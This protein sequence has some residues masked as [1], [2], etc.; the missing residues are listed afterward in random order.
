MKFNTSTKGSTRTVNYEGE[1]AYSMDAEL[2]L[3]SLVCTTFVENKFYEKANDLILRMRKLLPNVSLHFATNLAVY[4]RTEMHLRTIPLVLLVELLKLHGNSIEIESAIY[5]VINRA[6]ELAEILSYYQLANDRKGT[7]KLNRL[8]KSLKRGI[9]MAFHKFNEYQFAKYN[10][11]TSV[12]IRDAMFLS[13]PKPTTDEEKILFKK[14]ADDTLAI[15]YTWEV[16]LSEA[17]KTGRDKKEVWEELIDSGKLPYMATLRNLRNIVEANVSLEHIQKVADY[18]SDE[19]NV[20][21]SKQLPFRF[22]SAYKMIS[23]LPNT[24]VLVRALEKAM[25]YS[26]RNVPIGNER[27]MIATDVSGS[28]RSPLSKRSVIEYK[29]VGVVLSAILANAKDNVITSVFAERFELVPISLG[30]LATINEM[31]KIN[32]GFST[33]GYLIPKYMVDH[34]INIDKLFVFTD[35]QMWDSYN[36]SADVT[37][38]HYWHVYKKSFPNAKLYLFDLAGYGNTPVSVLEKD[39][40]FIAGWSDKVFDMLNYLENGERYVK[41]IKNL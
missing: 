13:H 7:K 2:E 38:K 5:K 40:T 17:G 3:Y 30:I 18:L 20:L 29:D 6:D 8:S 27:I 1:V 16:I 32:V 41:V 21:H 4:A 11:K 19:E 35:M 24:K 39:V 9:A 34:N 33:N 26:A 10:R 14:I 37:F 36:Y 25:E 22:Y 28:M 12:R 23:T 31:N 15:P